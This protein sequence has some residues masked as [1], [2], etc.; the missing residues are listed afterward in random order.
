MP[1]TKNP[2]EGQISKGIIILNKIANITLGL[3]ILA[4]AVLPIFD[5]THQ[6]ANFELVPFATAMLA[7]GFG[8]TT[9]L[10]IDENARNQ[11]IAAIDNGRKNKK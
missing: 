4:M 3:S 8:F 7:T 5:T 11:E 10:K 9:Q 2:N 6:Y 1:P